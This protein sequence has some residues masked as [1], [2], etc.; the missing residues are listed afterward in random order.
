MVIKESL[1]I[2][3]EVLKLIIKGTVEVGK[4]VYGEV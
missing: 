1:L 3:T 4:T 2:N